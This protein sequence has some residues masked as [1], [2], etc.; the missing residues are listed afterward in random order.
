MLCCLIELLS[1]IDLRR[2]LSDPPDGGT[3]PNPSPPIIPP[4]PS[5]QPELFKLA[6]KAEATKHP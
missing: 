1:N 6:G 5:T 3:P 4:N 2:F